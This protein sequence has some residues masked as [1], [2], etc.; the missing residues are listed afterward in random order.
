[1][2]NEDFERDGYSVHERVLDDSMRDDVVAAFESVLGPRDRAGERNG[3]M[4]PAIAELARAPS[5]RALVEPFLAAGAYA[6]RA[7]LFDKTPSSN[8][9]VAWHQDR[10]IP[11]ANRCSV[12]GF[13]QWSQKASGW[14]VEPPRTVQERIVAVRVDVV[15][16]SCALEA[17]GVPSV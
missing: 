3:L 10:V 1:M 14:H 8:W 16:Q 12:P 13:A 11:V 5:V 4:Q 9:P 6:F 7:T 2:S 15:H 17:Q